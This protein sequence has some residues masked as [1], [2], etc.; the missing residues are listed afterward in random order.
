MIVLPSMVVLHISTS[1]VLHA[2]QAME[3]GQFSLLFYFFLRNRI[4]F[5]IHQHVHIYDYSVGSLGKNGKNETV[6]SVQVTNSIF[7]GT[8]NGARIKTWAV[9]ILLFLL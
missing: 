8:Q 1:L 7:N 5:Q 4:I 6:E 3:S 2:V 9:F